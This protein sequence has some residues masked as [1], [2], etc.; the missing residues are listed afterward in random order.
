LNTRGIPYSE[1]SLRTKQDFDAFKQLS[2]LGGV[3]PVLVVGKNFLKGFLA[4][5]WHNELDIAG[6]PKTSIYRPRPAP[7]AGDSQ[8]APTEPAAQ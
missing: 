6:Y 1:K 5:Q 4:E 2:G 8:A 3:V 7:P